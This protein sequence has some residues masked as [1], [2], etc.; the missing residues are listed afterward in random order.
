MLKCTKE[1]R[2][3]KKRFKWVK[4]VWS[5]SLKIFSSRTEYNT[6]IKVSGYYC[7]QTTALIDYDL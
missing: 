3:H 5:I 1:E 2:T 6:N 4:L 7:E